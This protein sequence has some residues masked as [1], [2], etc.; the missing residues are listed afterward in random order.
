MDGK[1]FATASSKGTL[2]RVFETETGKKIKELRRGA[3]KAIINC[4]VFDVTKNLLACTS[5]KGTVH[6]FNMN[7][8]QIEAKN[9]TSK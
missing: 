4:L 9:P 1:L 8:T 3:D 6:V 5:D 7:C 2:I